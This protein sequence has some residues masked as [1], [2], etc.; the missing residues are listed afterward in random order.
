[1]P[2]CSSLELGV[3]WA[4]LEDSQEEAGVEGGRKGEW[5]GNGKEKERER[6]VG[7]IVGCE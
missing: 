7:G 3:S 4:G 6:G 2:S 5:E 1:M